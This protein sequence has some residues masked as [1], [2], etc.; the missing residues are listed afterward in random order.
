MKF[1]EQRT[2]IVATIGPS[3]NDHEILTNLIKAGVSCCR[4][5]FSHGT[6]ESHKQVYDLARQ[7]SKELDIPMSLML[8]T[9]G[10]EI[11]I[12]KMQNDACMIEKEI[13]K[14]L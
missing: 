12:G 4:V 5:N 14:I 3:S 1:N 2:K 11:R 10:P 7:V 8:D 6:E 9:K 13:K